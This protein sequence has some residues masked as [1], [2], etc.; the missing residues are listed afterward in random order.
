MVPDT[1]IILNDEMDDFSIPKRKNAFGL[2]PS[3]LNFISPGKRPFSSSAGTIIE[4][5][6]KKSP[7][8]NMIVG[9][10]ADKTQREENF[11]MAIGASGGS[12]IISSVAQTIL[13]V[14]DFEMGIE[15]AIESG[16]YHHQLIPNELEVETNIS[17]KI[18][19][20]LKKK[21]HQITP[22]PTGILMS[23]VHGVVKR[24]NE[25]EAHGDSRKHGAGDGF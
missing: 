6:T 16:R 18:I 25:I 24:G 11:L 14:I 19:D 8:L 17:K 15:K 12:R 7:L 20:D 2:P 23:A 3:P 1:G 9:V 4:S 5:I 22:I 13:S 21:G 10:I